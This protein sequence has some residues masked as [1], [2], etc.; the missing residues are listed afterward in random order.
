MHT[1]QQPTESEVVYDII[2]AGG[3][4]SACITAGRLAEADPSLKILIVES[5][6]HTKGLE[7]YVQP[8]RYFGNLALVKETFNIHISRPSPSLLGRTPIVPTG[9][10]TDIDILVMVYTRGAASDYDDWEIEYGNKGWGSKHL[11]PLLRKAETYQSGTTGPTAHGHSGPLKISFAPDL[12]NVTES[13][14]EVA[15][16]FDKERSI[17]DDINAFSECDKYGRLPRYVDDKTGRRSDAAHHY[18]YNQENNK[19]LKVLDRHRVIR[20]VLEGDQAVG[21]E[22][23]SEQNGG[24]TPL[25]IARASRLVVVAG[26]TFGSPAILERSG[27]GGKHVLEKAGIPPVVDLPG[28][29]E[30]YMDHNVVFLPFVATEDADTLDQL[31]RGSEEEIKPY[32]TQW[33][34]DGTG[35]M[36]HNGL[37]SAIKMRPNEEELAEIF[38]EF[39]YRWQTYFA[40]ADHHDKPVAILGPLA[41]YCGVNPDVPRG[42]YF[43]IAY[44]LAYPASAGNIHVTSADPN[45]PSDFHAGFLDDPADL[46]SL[47]WSYKKARELGRRL[48]YYAGDLVVGHPAFKETSSA[49]PIQPASPAAISAP[50][51]VYSK[52]DDDAIDEYHRR[53]VETTWHS[54]GT[55]AMKPREQRGV[56]DERLNVHGIQ[57]LKVA[58]CSIAPGNVGANMYSTAIAIG[59]KA[60][61]IIAQDLGIQG[62]TEQ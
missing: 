6:P 23:A 44:F 61:V 45:T 36:S 43:S 29:G 60:A 46:V 30:N 19:N 5:G 9:H 39:D 42:K 7:D 4:A 52:E 31:F 55:C 59:E 25:L 35:L 62:V 48:K 56:V 8:A 11:I 10:A 17:V 14:L 16:A 26:G 33:L 34:K 22:Y 15:A 1:A 24:F 37:D 18:I 38:P 40:K 53:N 57:G 27:I 12:I 51:I 47:R 20:V 58:D 28:V 32:E 13:F 2:F 3:G 21:I 54:I 50:K 49:Q 41:A